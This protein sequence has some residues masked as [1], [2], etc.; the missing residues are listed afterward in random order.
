M[1]AETVNSL[2]T[3]SKPLI[4]TDVLLADVIIPVACVIHEYAATVRFILLLVIYVSA[5]ETI[6]A[7]TARV[8]LD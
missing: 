1:L 8:T 4:S 2:I 5:R 6:V 3:P 7:A